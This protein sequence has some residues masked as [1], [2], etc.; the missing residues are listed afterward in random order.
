[1]NV[2][3]SYDGPSKESTS[4]SKRM[5]WDWGYR[6]GQ[7]TLPVNRWLRSKIGQRWDDIY[8]EYCGLRPGELRYKYNWELDRVEKDCTEDG[9][10]IFNSKGD[11]VTYGFAVVDGVL[12]EIKRKKYVRMSTEECRW[13]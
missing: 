8:S 10:R 4:P 13:H 12:R 6:K 9:G 7:Q 2:D 5:A 3:E 11:E 1:M